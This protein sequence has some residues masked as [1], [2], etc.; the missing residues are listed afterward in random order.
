MQLTQQQ[1]IVRLKHLRKTIE[2]GLHSNIPPCC[3]KYYITKQIWR[4]GK[5]AA[6][7]NK[8]RQKNHNI[9]FK[10]YVPCPNCVKKRRRFNKLHKCNC[11]HA[12]EQEGEIFNTGEGKFIIEN[13]KLK[14]LKG[15]Q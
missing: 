14:K 15:K 10:G 1:I 12:K 9:T 11:Y 8:L 4:N 13:G 7:S 6:L 3:I 2:C 5:E